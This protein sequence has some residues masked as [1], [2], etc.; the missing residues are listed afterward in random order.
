MD[1][2]LAKEVNQIAKVDFKT[3]I[4]GCDGHSPGMCRACDLRTVYG[5]YP[6]AEKWALAY[7]QAEEPIPNAW[8]NALIDELTSEDE[9]YR[10]ELEEN[11][12]WFGVRWV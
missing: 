1:K 2:Y 10:S 12:R 7:V 9:K 11:V 4:G 5:D 3:H 8:R 6:L